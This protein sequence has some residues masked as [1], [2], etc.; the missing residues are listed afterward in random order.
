MTNKEKTALL[1]DFLG[2]ELRQGNPMEGKNY[3][4][5]PTPFGNIDADLIEFSD[6]K[7]LWLVILKL[8]EKYGYNSISNIITE[9]DVFYPKIISDTNQLFEA[10]VRYLRYKIQ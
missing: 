2:W 6:I 3:F 8:A 7:Y 4:Y 10:T 5:Y 1:A 9:I